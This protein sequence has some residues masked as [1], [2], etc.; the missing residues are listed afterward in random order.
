MDDRDYNTEAL[1]TYYGLGAVTFGP[2]IHP[3]TQV[4]V[5]RLDKVDKDIMAALPNLKVIAFNATGEDH[6]DLKYAQSKNIQIVSLKGDPFT[7]EVPASSEHAFGL[8]LSCF[9]KYGKA[10]TFPDE[11][12]A[13]DA[14]RGHDLK[15]KSLGIIG[16]GR[17]GQN[18]ENYAMA[19]GM[20]VIAYD[21]N[22]TQ[23]LQSR[24]Y[25]LRYADVILLSLPLNAQTRDSFGAKDF[26]VMKETAYLVN[27]SRGDI[28]KKDALRKALWDCTI[29]GAAVDVTR[30]DDRVELLEYAQEHDDLIVTNHIGGCTIDSAH[31]TE[32]HI[33]KKVA[34]ILS[35]KVAINAE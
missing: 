34:G 13:R 14:Y 7:S 32:L 33:A 28:I 29:A 17:I 6:I 31:M 2:E 16:Y 9:R 26:G 8:I 20:D 11:P 27:I 23:T 21:S 12:L 19:F 10:F 25:V 24:E 30:E 22:T 15:G 1:S 5:V 4:L 3:D 35:D 18:V